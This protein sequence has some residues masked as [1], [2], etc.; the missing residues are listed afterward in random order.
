MAAMARCNERARPIKTLYQHVLGSSAVGGIASAY[1]SGYLLEHLSTRQVFGLTALFPLLVTVIS[2]FI[3]EERR[4]FDTR[5][6]LQIVRDQASKLWAALRDKA[7]YLPILFL[8]LWQ[9]TPTSDSA[10]FY[11]LTNEI[12]LRPEFLGRVRLGSSIASLV[13][14]WLYQRYLRAVPIGRV[15][16]FTTL[17][18]VPLGLSQLILVYHLNTSWGI[19]DN[20]FAFGDSVVLTVLGQLA[21]MP[22]LVLAAKVCPP[23]VEGTVFA[24]LMSVFNGAGAVG[25]ELGAWLTSVLGV[26]DHDFKNLGTLLL[27]CNLSSLLSLP[28][29]VLLPP[30][31]RSATDQD[32]E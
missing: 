28:F 19:P 4:P 25:A 27:V 29:L 31:M 13:G 17:A 9:A 5:E 2:G 20:W 26:T 12:G 32:N 18:S 6:T 23:G 22:T 8:F 1:L 21:F 24:T 10:F 30:E 3:N 11:F 15:L 14:V 16:L 7:I